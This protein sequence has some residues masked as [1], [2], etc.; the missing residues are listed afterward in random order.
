MFIQLTV[1][2]AC[3][4]GMGIATA[5]TQCMQAPSLVSSAV[6]QTTTDAGAKLHNV[7]ATSNMLNDKIYIFDGK[8][9]S[10]VSPGNVFFKLKQKTLLDPR[11]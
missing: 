9:D 7:D 5:V 10:T 8:A 2:F 11:R 1:P 4:E 6:L 3:T